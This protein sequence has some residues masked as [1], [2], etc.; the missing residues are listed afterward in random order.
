MKPHTP[1]RA[2]DALIGD[3]ERNN[4]K[5]NKK[6][7]TEWATNSAALDHLVTY[8]PHGSQEGPILKPPANRGNNN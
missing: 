1:T 2:I 7:E 5:K 3:E 6:K 4:R 8:D